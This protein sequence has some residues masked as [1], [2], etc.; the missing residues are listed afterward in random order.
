MLYFSGDQPTTDKFIIEKNQVKVWK[1]INLLKNPLYVVI[2]LLPAN[3]L[4]NV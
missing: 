4:C 3:L 2:V 1:E